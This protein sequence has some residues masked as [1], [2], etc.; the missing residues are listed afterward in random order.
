MADRKRTLKW[1]LTGTAL[2]GIAALLILFLQLRRD[3]GQ[4]VPLPDTATRAL[5]TLARLHQTA[6]QNGKV[7]WDLTAESAQLDA[8]TGRMILNSPVVVF[9]TQDGSQVR[10]TAMQGVLHTRTNDM[11]ASGNVH[12]RNDRYLLQTEA[13]DYKHKDRILLSRVPVKITG[14][15]FDLRADKMTYNLENNT[16]LFEGSVEGNLNADMAL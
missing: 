15:V 8:D 6:T 7:Q 16:T 12:L 5:L 9:Y 10:L 13:L 11:Q 2:A 4:P 14:D 3:Q 1:I